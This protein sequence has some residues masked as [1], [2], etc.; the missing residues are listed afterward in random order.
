MS[1]YA[2]AALRHRGSEWDHRA[3]RRD[4]E[5]FEEET[6]GNGNNQLM[7]RRRDT[8]V[9]SV[10][11]LHRFPPPIYGRRTRSAGRDRSY[12]NDFVEVRG[13]GFYSIKRPHIAYDDT[14]E[15]NSSFFTLTST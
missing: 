10:E 11:E 8:S 14:C 6:R 3:R 7:H 9:D 15:W 12:D 2:D 5:F 1:P 13:T 4:R